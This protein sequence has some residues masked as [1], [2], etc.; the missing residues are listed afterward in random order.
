MKA[1]AV[2]AQRVTKPSA[3]SKVPTVAA[4][5]VESVP[6]SALAGLKAE[7]AKAEGDRLSILMVTPEAHPFA[8]TGGLAEVAAALPQAL[9]ALGHEVTLVL[10]RYRRVDISATKA[11][12]ISF[13]LGSRPVSLSIL[14]QQPPTGIAGVKV[15]FVDAPDLFDRDGL[16]GDASGDY[17]D[18]AWRFAVLS[19]AA[20]EYA[21]AVKLRPSVIHAHDWQTGLVPVYQKM[22]FR[23]T[24]SS[25]ACPLCSRSTTW[26]SRAFSR[27]RRSKRS[28]LGW[29]VL[30]VQAME[31]WGQISYLKAGINF[32]EK[33]TTVSPTYACEITTPEL[34][35]GFDG[36]LR[37]RAGDLVGHPQRHRHHALEP[38]ATTSTSPRRS[39]RKT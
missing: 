20:L 27:R 15:A 5:I 1:P 18:N 9:A 36:I 10:P 22:L 30:D 14:E 34:G 35:F 21:R 26:H 4:S 12:P 2:R 6:Q 13:R 3:P 25:A 7:I 39:R 16:Y 11:I 8:K 24:R 19:R 31:Y 33:I 38:G 29:N 17:P 37:R 28:D 32:S 23:L